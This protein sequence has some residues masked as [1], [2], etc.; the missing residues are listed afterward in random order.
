MAASHLMAACLVL[1][2]LFLQA[3]LNSCSSWEDSEDPIRTRYEQWIARYDRRYRD[4]KEKEKRFQIYRTNVVLIDTI[5]SLGLGYT[6]TD[7][8]F[9]DLTNEEFRDK[10]SCLGLHPQHRQE[11]PTATQVCLLIF[12]FCYRP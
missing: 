10:I 9:A 3:P 5:N 2:L 7:N 12:M 11:T 4:G 1:L 8:K 6:L